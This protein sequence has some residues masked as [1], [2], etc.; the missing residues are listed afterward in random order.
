MMVH[1]RSPQVP[2]GAV[3]LTE[4]GFGKYAAQVGT[5]IDHVTDR[6][7]LYS[8]MY[9]VEFPDGDGAWLRRFEFELFEEEK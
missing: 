7:S 5:V 3:V 1:H 4:T 8:G 6:S 2:I 9:R